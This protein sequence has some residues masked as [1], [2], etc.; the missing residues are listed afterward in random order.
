MVTFSPCQ[1]D[2]R[3]CGKAGGGGEYGVQ[4]GFGW[5][6]GVALMLLQQYKGQLDDLTK[7]YS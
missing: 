3:H 1:Y 2:A 4:V 7:D 6:N 5:S